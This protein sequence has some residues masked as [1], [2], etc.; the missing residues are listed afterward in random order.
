MNML[1]KNKRLSFKESLAWSFSNI[2]FRGRS[3]RSEFWWFTLF[4]I[5][6]SI[7]VSISQRCLEEFSTAF[8]E[9]ISWVLVLGLLVISYFQLAVTFRRLHDVGKSGW[10]AGILAIL[11]LVANIVRIFIDEEVGASLNIVYWASTL[12]VIVGFCSVDSQNGDNKYGESPKYNPDFE[13][14]KTDFESFLESPLGC[15]FAFVNL[16][17]YLGI[18]VG[19]GCLFAHWVCN[20]DPF[21]TY[22][23]YSGI[24]HGIFFIPNLVRSWFGDTLYKAELYTTGYNVFWWLTVVWMVMSI[25]ISPFSNNRN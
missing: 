11:N 18:I 6:L 23:W 22:S 14:V 25:I 15:L 20:I 4:F 7:A 2:S 19:V 3:R 10:W 9:I 21:E 1:S 8:S 24:W 5:C 16:L 13:R 12:V 17:F